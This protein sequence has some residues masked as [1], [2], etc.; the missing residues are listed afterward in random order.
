MAIRESL[1]NAKSSQDV[2]DEGMLQIHEMSMSKNPEKAARGRLL[3]LLHP[4]IAQWS[5]DE[6]ARGTH[7]GDMIYALGHSLFSEAASLILAY[8]KDGE[9]E[10]A[11][12][13]FADHVQKS[14]YSIVD[15]PGLQDQI[16]DAEEL[17]MVIAKRQR[18]AAH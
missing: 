17:T 16:K 14:L 11:M 15:D 8:A 13:N 10:S 3:K 9:Q 1:K 6:Q 12:K 4:M 18:E 5:D 7:P 2:F